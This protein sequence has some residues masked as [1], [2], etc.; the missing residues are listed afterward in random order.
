MQLY[1]WSDS[2]FV[3]KENFMSTKSNKK[4]D[5]GQKGICR[6]EFLLSGITAASGI[7]FAGKLSRADEGVQVEDYSKEI[8]LPS[9]GKIIE[10][11]REIPIIAKADVVVVGGGPSG[12]TSAISAARAGVSVILVERYNHLGGLWT[13]GLVLPLLSTHAVNKEGVRQQVVGGIGGEIAQRLVDMKMAKNLNQPIVDP[14]AAKY[15]LDLM[16]RD[17]GVN[18]FY[19][20]FAAN[21]IT[22]SGRIE[23][24][25]IESKSGRTAIKPKVVID[26]TGDGDI[27]AWAGESYEKMNTYIGLNYRIGNVNNQLKDTKENTPIRGVRWVN[28]RG[29]AGNALNVFELS[30]LQTD[31]RISAFEKIQAMRAKKGYEDLFLLDTASQIGV[32]MSRIL[33]GKY[34]LTLDETLIHKKYKDAIAFGGAWTRVKD[35]TPQN[36]PAWQIPYGCLVPKKTINLLVAGRCVSIEKSLSEDMRVIG[37]CM[38]TGH[39]AGAAAAAAIQ[40]NISVQDNDIEKIQKILI[41]QKAYLG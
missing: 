14:E 18:I 6:R 40:N 7:M 3:K 10:P 13:G 17:A 34:K 38:V 37:P 1:Y 20:S 21:I 4:K 30:K 28:I 22:Q 27:F 32:R 24:V 15:V 12:I 33:N 16:A 29:K 31:L 9:L 25:I 23:A 35:F 8:P 39:A 5:H 11:S 26:C 2:S 36:R 19:H 41:Q